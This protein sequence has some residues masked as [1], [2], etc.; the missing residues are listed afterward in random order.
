MSDVE[1]EAG[2][3]AALAP[4]RRA[5]RWGAALALLGLALAMLSAVG[6]T[7]L[8]HRHVVIGLGDLGLVA[9]GRW[10]GAEA[11]DEWSARE[12][13][14]QRRRWRQRL[15]ALVVERRARRSPVELV[16]AIEAVVDEGRLAVVRVAAQT[17]VVALAVVFLSGGWQA[18][19][20]VVALVAVAVPLYV[21]AGRHAAALA[22]KYQE[23]RNRLAERQ[24]DLLSHSLELRALGAVEYGAGEIDALSRA[25]HEVALTAIR[26]ALGSSL[27]TE[28]LGGVSVGLVAMDVGFG[29]L[30]GRISL[31]R[32]LI[33]VLA[34]S[35]FFA[36]VR[37]YGTEFHRREAASA[38]R[39]T[40][41]AAPPPDRDA[42]DVL[43]AV[44]L[45][46][47]AHDSALNLELAPGERL[48]IVGPSG[49]G[50]TTLAH[51]LLG[52]RDARS[53]EVRRGPDP[54]AYV[55]AATSLIPGTLGE[56]LRLGR[57]LPDETL[58]AT[59]ASLGLGAEGFADLNRPLSADG[60]GFST[61]ERVRIVLARALLGEPRL[62]I[63]DDVAGV[64]DGA[65]RAAVRD[66]LEARSRL[67]IIE[68]S[69][70]DTLLI[71]SSPTLRLS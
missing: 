53:G 16:D 3:L 37:R 57:D 21:R 32:A 56:N 48:A 38:A 36:L 12:S 43:Q 60:E 10:L 61:G 47:E 2:D 34:T 71:G 7:E 65:S 44:D 17:S 49:V 8:A 1:L 33:S 24:L 9:L 14:R 23:R 69:V 28:F 5:G 58:H 50:K 59:L 55:S 45:V 51:T 40:L 52:W 15:V 18:L 20:I 25:E 27:V 67:A 22:A 11:T 35:E 70:D 41:E 42:A 63:L 19:G 31:L 46:T 4:S 26:A 54:V 13:R 64:L 29:L 66:V 39:E 68:I 62:L 30:D 6:L